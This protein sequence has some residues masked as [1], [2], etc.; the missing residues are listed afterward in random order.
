MD[1]WYFIKGVSFPVILYLIVSKDN[2]VAGKI[3]DRGQG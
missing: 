2:I 1:W 3:G